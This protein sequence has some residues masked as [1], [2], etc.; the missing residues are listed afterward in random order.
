MSNESEKLNVS[1]Q[2][3]NRRSFGNYFFLVK[4][5]GMHNSI[6]TLTINNTN[7]NEQN[8]PQRGYSIG[9]F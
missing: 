6:L 1:H 7:A 8:E 3:I 5:F 4:H 9:H 2:F